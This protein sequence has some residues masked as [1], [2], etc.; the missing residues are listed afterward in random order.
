MKN[1]KSI[2]LV[3][4]L[5]AVGFA[6]VSTTLIINGTANFG[7][8]NDDFDVIFTKS[9]IDGVDMTDT[10]ISED[11]KSITFTTS[12]LAKVGDK[13]VLNFVVT[14]NSTQYDAN[15]IMQCV[16]EG[17]KNEYYTITNT[18]PSV[19]KSKSIVNG[20]VTATLK[21]VSIE[22]ITETKINY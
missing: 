13:S 18:I 1:R 8:N 9:V 12:E 4:L 3:V 5:L 15:V 17:E 6:A 10:T 14:N 11:G 21:K 20:T 22:E 16:A 19:I 7:T 2:L